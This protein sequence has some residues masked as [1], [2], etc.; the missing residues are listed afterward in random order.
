[1]NSADLSAKLN[2]IVRFLNSIKDES[3]WP[4]VL[5]AIHPDGDEG[6]FIT[7]IESDLISVDTIAWK[8]YDTMI[9]KIGSVAWYPAPAIT[10]ILYGELGGA[11]EYVHMLVDGGVIQKLDN[12]GIMLY[13][14]K[15][16]LLFKAIE[17]AHTT[18]LEKPHHKAVFKSV[19]LNTYT[20]H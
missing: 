3:G 8:S 1:M 4:D 17:Y 2:T 18:K 16:S 19:V 12:G 13:A 5:S 15:D 10:K 14:R 9:D 11:F 7:K 20:H 6:L